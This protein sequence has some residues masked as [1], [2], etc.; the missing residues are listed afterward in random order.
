MVD[1]NVPMYA[2]TDYSNAPKV[3][4]REAVIRNVPSEFLRHVQPLETARHAE[5]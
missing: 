2:A 3:T 4:R 1:S 5:I